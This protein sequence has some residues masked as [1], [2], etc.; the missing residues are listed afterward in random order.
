MALFGKRK[1]PRLERLAHYLAGGIIIIKGIDKADHFDQHPL[2]CLFLFFM[3]A[4]II[5]AN[6][7]HHYFEGIFKEFKAFLFFSEGLVLA[8]ISYYYFA[9]GKKALPYAYALTAVAYIIFSIVMYRK[10]S[11]IIA[12]KAISAGGEPISNR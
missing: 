11:R 1:D 5:F 7:K 2:V 6:Y 9:E 8:V 3:G 12:E 4:F 10:K